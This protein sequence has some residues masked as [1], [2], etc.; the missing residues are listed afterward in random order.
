MGHPGLG[1]RAG[2]GSRAGLCGSGERET[3]CLTKSQILQVIVSDGLPTLQNVQTDTTE[4]I[5]VGVIDLGQEADLGRGHGIVVGQ[6]QLE[7]KYST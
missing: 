3:S 2:P 7:P 6:E 1:L 5:N 4:A